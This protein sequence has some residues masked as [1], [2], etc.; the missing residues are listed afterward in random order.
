MDVFVW[1]WE[2]EYKKG[3]K[4]RGQISSWEYFSSED[5]SHS[6]LATEIGCFPFILL[7]FLVLTR[8]YTGSDEVVQYHYYSETIVI[9]IIIILTVLIYL[10]E[11]DLWNW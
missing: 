3:K 9:I 7:L 8:N 10:E 11:F 5:Y 6:V 4:G 2:S 1:V